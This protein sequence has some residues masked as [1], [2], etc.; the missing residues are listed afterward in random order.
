MIPVRKITHAT[1]ETPDPERLAQYYEEVLGLARIGRADGAIHLASCVGQPMVVLAK[2]DAP[3]CARLSF[4]V[5]AD[6]D[7]ADAARRLAPH[8]I[9]CER[10]SD[11]GPFAADAVIFRDLNGT[12][13]EIHRQGA[14][15]PETA[16]KAIAPL[17]LGH[18]AFNVLDAQAAVAFYEKV[19]GFRLSDWIEDF[20]AFMRCGPDHHTLNFL[21]RG[22][23]IKMH[24]IAFQL[25]D[26][27]HVQTACEEL[28]RRRIEVLWG[29]GRH[30]PGHNIF[31]YH[32]DPDGQIIELF[33]ELDTMSDEDLGYFDPRPWHR[34]HPQRPKVWRGGEASNLWGP[35]APDNF[36]N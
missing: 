7:L 20:F 33:A 12:E 5:G 19:L 6:V 34:D 17:K 31:T 21:A 30:G 15:E 28:S 22:G 18:V 3:R 26:W 25:R 13:I 24:H 4:H 10:R 23:R 29:P 8:G 1:F 11:P 32:R 16:P 36:R 14:L 35:L 2:G 27:S 9:A